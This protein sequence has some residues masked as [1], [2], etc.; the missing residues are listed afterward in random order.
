MVETGSST[1]EDGDKAS[2]IS[3]PEV[4]TPTGLEGKTFEVETYDSTVMAESGAGLG[5]S[6]ELNDG[7][8][9]KKEEEQERR[10]VASTNAELKQYE[11]EAET[12]VTAP[13]AD[14]P[15]DG[16]SVSAKSRTPVFATYSNDASPP[17]I[18]AP[19]VV[20]RSQDS[21]QD[22][23]DIGETSMEQG[24]D[25]IDV[26]ETP[27]IGSGSQTPRSEGTFESVEE[28]LKEADEEGSGYGDYLDDY[29]TLPS[30]REAL[31]NDSERKIPVKCSDCAIETD[32]LSLPDHECSPRP[33]STTVFPPKSPQLA[34]S[35]SPASSPS[36]QR[37]QVVLDAI[38]STTAL[39]LPEDVDADHED[40]LADY[41]ESRES[42]ELDMPQDV[43]VE[44]PKRRGATRG[45]GGSGEF[46]KDEED[47]DSGWAT[48]VGRS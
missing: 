48:V 15:V 36:T 17:L 19:V 23:S 38:P 47:D 33:L 25:S 21:P 34:S 26:F 1:S 9:E 31:T 3:A 44:S 11:G 5:M 40:P 20:S 6:V 22:E 32:L 42:L 12:D 4:E 43:E 28:P 13:R 8:R 14:Q 37:T 41:L 46:P 18:P 16:T 30:P 45:G 27:R 2:H 7:E 39:E 24:D 29:A 35:A 10:M